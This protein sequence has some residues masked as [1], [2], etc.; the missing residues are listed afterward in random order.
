MEWFGFIRIL[1]FIMAF[2]YNL[3]FLAILLGWISEMIFLA[4]TEDTY[5][6]NISILD[7]VVNMVCIYNTIIHSPIFILNFGI[8]WKE[9]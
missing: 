2:D 8:I 4:L 7:V 1:S 9:M 5:I 3:I 6:D